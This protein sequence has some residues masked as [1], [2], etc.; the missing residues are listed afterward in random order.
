MFLRKR[1]LAAAVAGNALEFYDFTTYA[2]FAIQIGDTFFPAKDAF[3]RLMLTLVTFGASFLMRPVG[4]AVI[5]RYADRMGRKPAML[6]SFGLMGAGVLGLALTP[7]YAQIGI[8]APILI[9]L[10][11]LVQG[12]ALGGEVGPTT[13]FLLEVAPPERRGLYC[14]L[15]YVGQGISGAMAGVAGVILA[16][17]LSAA[18]LQQFG[19]RIAF[20]FGVLVVPLGFILRRNLPETLHVTDTPALPAPSDS[21]I[22]RNAILGLLSIMGST[23]GVYVLNYMATYSQNVLHLKAN[24]AFAATFVFGMCNVVFSFLA[25]MLSDR[26][27]RRP[28]MIWTRVILVFITWP[29]FLL[30]TTHVNAVTLL[31]ATAVLAVFTQSGGAA[32]RVAI[33][34]SFPPRLR[35]A[36]MATIYAVGVAVFGGTTQPIIAWLMHVTGNILAPAWWLIGTTIICLGATLLM[37]ETAPVKTG[38]TDP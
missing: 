24:I 37:E 36:S 2:F 16:S 17:V 25:G 1:D 8:A 3:T 20:G 22:V 33:T 7:S 9:V 28:V 5:G 14:S 21:R 32:S 19:W 23:T 31:T 12:F 27:G 34:E 18:Q 26:I 35:S 11:R 15:Q 4:A 38:R 29:A 6:L 30:I 10:L 13:A